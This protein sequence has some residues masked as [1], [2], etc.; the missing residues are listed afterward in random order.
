MKAGS[1]LIWNSLLPHCNIQSNSPK[2]RFCQY[3]RMFPAT[4]KYQ[5]LGRIVRESYL[6]GKRPPY[7]S[8]GKKKI[9]SNPFLKYTNRRPKSSNYFYKSRNWSWRIPS[10]RII[11]LGLKIVNVKSWKMTNKWDLF[12]FKNLLSK[13]LVIYLFQML[14]FTYEI[15]E[16]STL[17]NKENKNI[18]PQQ[19]DGFFSFLASSL[20]VAWT[21]L[22]FPWE[23][24]AIFFGNF[25][26]NKI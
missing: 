17:K 1:L 18:H 14:L 5:D 25:F 13:T 23:D 22:G 15:F 7:F 16:Y 8:T 9:L 4:K 6:T 24:F 11:D 20:L 26:A 12:H 2:W 3:I 19:D 21:I 10:T